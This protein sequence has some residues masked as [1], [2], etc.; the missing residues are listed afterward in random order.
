MAWARAITHIL[1][2]LVH[3]PI[4][5]GYQTSLEGKG[6]FQEGAVHCCQ[7]SLAALHVLPA[8]LGA[9]A[10]FKEPGLVCQDCTSRCFQGGWMFSQDHFGVTLTMNKAPGQA[11]K[12][13]LH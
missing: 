9:H 11:R 7:D 3:F 5:F 1:G 8:D 2:A 6:Q 13:E 12:S 4:S 10:S